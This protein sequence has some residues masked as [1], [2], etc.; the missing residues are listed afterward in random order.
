M[1]EGYVIL[2]GWGLGLVRKPGRKG[3]VIWALG[4]SIKDGHEDNDMNQARL[5]LYNPC[6]LKHVSPGVTVLLASLIWIR[7]LS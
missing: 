1:G 6:L 3:M 4:L 2:K 5:F 7:L